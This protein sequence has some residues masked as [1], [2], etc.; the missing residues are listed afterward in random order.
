VKSSTIQRKVLLLS[1]ILLGILALG[2]F[3]D[4]ISNAIGLITPNGTYFGTIAAATVWLAA[5][6]IAKRRA[7]LWK[8]DHGT[9]LRVRGIGIKLRLVLLGSVIL[10]WVPRFG[11][12]ISPGGTTSERE[13]Q[14]LGPNESGEVLKQEIAKLRREIELQGRIQSV[15]SGLVTKLIEQ[16][17]SQQKL[18]RSDIPFTREELNSLEKRTRV[19]SGYAREIGKSIGESKQDEQSRRLEER[20]AALERLNSDLLK[21]LD[22]A[23]LVAEERNPSALGKLLP[24]EEG[25]LSMGVI[26]SPE[27]SSVYLRGEEDKFARDAGEAL[28][29]GEPTR[30]RTGSYDAD[31]QRC[32]LGSGTCVEL[33][34]ASSDGSSAHI[35][36]HSGRGSRLADSLLSLLNRSQLDKILASFAGPVCAFYEKAANRQLRSNTLT[37]GLKP[38]FYHRGFMFGYST[39]QVFPARSISLFR[40]PAGEKVTEEV[41][42]VRRR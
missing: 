30:L 7:L 26:K 17:E 4:S 1:Y 35:Q 32:L 42:R 20:L 11:D 40:S 27:G 38:L 34:L 39:V 13:S 23:R 22:L 15:N 3:L 5:E 14:H 37:F 8:T 25:S 31:S 41:E 12:W 9:W 28:K 24:S 33:E 2:A 6:T 29:N 18:T 36:W 16:L 19:F 10:L 21:T